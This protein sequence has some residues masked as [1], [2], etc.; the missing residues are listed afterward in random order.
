MN[1]TAPD[2]LF[3]DQIILVTGAGDG[4]GRVASL[5][6]A[7]K[8]ATVVLLGRNTHK[9]ETVYDEIKALGKAEAAIYP[10]N[11]EGASPRDYEELAE[12]LKREFGQLNGLLH[13]AAYLGANAPLEHY[14]IETWFKVMQINLNA[15]FVMTRELIPLMRKS[16]NASILFTTDDKTTAYWGA[17][18][19]SKYAVI[20]LMKILADELDSTPRVR[21]NAIDPGPVRTGMRIRAFPGEDPNQNPPPE[22]VMADYLY[23]MAND[24]PDTGKVFSCS[25]E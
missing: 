23:V 14:D 19:T 13:N 5:A 16:D 12:T 6:Y 20:G 15:P 25:S 22:D 17:Y 1:Y 4:I 10:L 3:E 2:D 21:V 24:C 7:D 11:F 8:G 18:G 9:L